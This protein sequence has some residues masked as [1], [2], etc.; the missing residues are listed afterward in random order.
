MSVR[1][2]LIELHFPA[3]ARRRMFRRLVAVT[4]SAFGASVPDV[5]RLPEAQAVA[6]FARFTRAESE[7][8]MENGAGEE[9][10]RDRLR[11]GAREM[12]R[13]A[14]RILG[15]SSARDVMRALRV[16]Y[17]AVGIDFEGSAPTGDATIHRCA[18][19]SEYAPATCRFMAALDEGMAEGISG[20]SRLVFTSR[21]TE[22]APCCRATLSRPGPA[23]PEDARDLSGGGQVPQVSDSRPPVGSGFAPEQDAPVHEPTPE[24]GQ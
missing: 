19:S 13:S 3:W 7:R 1:L 22:G 5:D 11:E 10:V 17:S 20:G 16:L 9:P 6:G 23:A 12:G 14:R 15:V 8:V 21:M 2:F 24:R 4:A 18:F